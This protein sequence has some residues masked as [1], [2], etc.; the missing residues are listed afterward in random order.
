MNITP[1]MRAAVRARLAERL[2]AGEAIT[3]H[4]VIA[5]LFGRPAAVTPTPTPDAP[6]AFVVTVLPRP[7]RAPDV[8]A[9]TPDEV[10]SYAAVAATLGVT[11]GTVR[12]YCAPSRGKLVRLR[13]GVSRASL[14]ALIAGKAA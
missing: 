2:G 4:D 11:L 3:R 8:V 5:E 6:P 9:M 10:V 1:T 7:D 13:D 12:A 14:D